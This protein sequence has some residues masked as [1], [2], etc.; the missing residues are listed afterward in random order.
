MALPIRK[1]NFL[2]SGKSLEAVGSD[3]CQCGN[4]ATKGL[5]IQSK[6]EVFHTAVQFC[7]SF[8][9]TFDSLVHQKPLSRASSEF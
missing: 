8:V 6:N 7:P 1:L 4:W 2:I 3:S 9:L 5:A